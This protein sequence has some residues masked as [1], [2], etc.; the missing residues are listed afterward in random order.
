[1]V[2]RTYNQDKSAQQQNN[3]RK[4]NEERREEIKKKKHT[5][6]DLI[7]FI[8]HIKQVKP[9]IWFEERT[10]LWN[11]C[12]E[13]NKKRRLKFEKQIKMLNTKHKI[14]NTKRINMPSIA[15][16]NSYTTDKEKICRWFVISFCYAHLKWMRRAAATTMTNIKILLLLLKVREQ[17]KKTVVFSLHVHQAHRSPNC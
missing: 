14:Q 5:T 6:N 7:S 8:S 16:L 10:I 4:N 1:M 15:H 17:K 13:G 9:H 11:E 12:F 2:N 3:E